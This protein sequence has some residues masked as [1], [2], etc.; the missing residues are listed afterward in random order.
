MFGCVFILVFSYACCFVYVTF[1]LL[2]DCLPA[3]AII[4]QIA[5]CDPEAYHYLHEKLVLQ[6]YDPNDFN[7]IVLRLQ[8][9][10]SCLRINC[11]DVGT[12]QSSV[13]PQCIEEIMPVKELSG[14][15][16]TTDVR[17]VCNS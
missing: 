15:S 1:L 13:V 11:A 2:A 4:P 9:V 3:L 7:E 10:Y 16:F 6:I 12:L 8:S 17:T 14:Y 5:A